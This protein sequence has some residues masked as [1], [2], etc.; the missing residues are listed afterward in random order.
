MADEEIG[1]MAVRHRVAEELQQVLWDRAINLISS[2]VLN[3]SAGE[4]VTDGGQVASVW[5]E[6]AEALEFH[7]RLAEEMRRYV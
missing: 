1:S 7:S 2:Q 5:D 4:R 6:Q 3:H